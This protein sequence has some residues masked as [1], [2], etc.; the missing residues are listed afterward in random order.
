MTY[1][2]YARSHS[3]YNNGGKPLV[4]TRMAP[5]ILNL[6][7]V[8]TIQY[9]RGRSDS[10]YGLYAHNPYKDDSTRRIKS[11]RARLELSLLTH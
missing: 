10:L 5:A 1:T 2:P 6:R 11:P 3:G 8:G 9:T 7:Y 4:K